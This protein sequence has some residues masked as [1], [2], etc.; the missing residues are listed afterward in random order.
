MIS[1]MLSGSHICQPILIES[2]NCSSKK[3]YKKILTHRR[4][5]SN[6]KLQSVVIKQPGNRTTYICFHNRSSPSKK[7]KTTDRDSLQRPTNLC[8]ATY[9]PESRPK[10]YTGALSKCWKGE[11]PDFN[12]CNGCEQEIDSCIDA[13]CCQQAI[14]NGTGAI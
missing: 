5:T 2:A 14:A 10:R 9:I 4:T 11:L 1:T 7:Q 8:T 12:H 3:S 13:C 6:V